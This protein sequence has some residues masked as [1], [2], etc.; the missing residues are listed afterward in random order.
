[1]PPRAEEIQEKEEM[2]KKY[3]E[4]IRAAGEHCH[5]PCTIWTDGSRLGPEAVGAAFCW[6][7]GGKRAGVPA[8]LVQER[9]APWRRSRAPTSSS[10]RPPHTWTYGEKRRSLLEPA[11]TWLEGHR[12]FPKYTPGG[13][14]R[15]AFRI[16]R[17]P[18]AS[19]IEAG[20]C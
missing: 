7:G 13:L 10:D 18:E 20:E 9:R 12:P 1:M 6:F 3:E 11:R 14:R 4:A 16:G 8:H 17:E 15:G 2:T 19:G 5:D